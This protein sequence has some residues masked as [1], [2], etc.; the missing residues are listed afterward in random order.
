MKRTALQVLIAGVLAG[1]I[2]FFPITAAFASGPS[3]EVGGVQVIPPLVVQ[4]DG[5][6]SPLCFDLTTQA[7]FSLGFSRGTSALYMMRFSDDRCTTGGVMLAGWS[8]NADATGA[9]KFQASSS[10]GANAFECANVGC[11]LQLGSDSRYFFDS[12]SMLAAQGSFAA[13]SFLNAN[14][15]TAGMTFSSNAMTLTGNVTDGASAVGITLKNATTLANASAKLVSG[16]N[17]ATEAFYIKPNGDYCM[18]TGTCLSSATGSGQGD[19][20]GN[21]STYSATTDANVQIGHCRAS[22]GQTAFTCTNWETAP[23]SGT[24]GTPSVAATGQ[25]EDRIWLKL[26]TSLANTVVGAAN[27]TSQ[28]TLMLGWSTTTTFK[29]W[30]KS[31]TRNTSYRYAIGLVNTPSTVIASDTPTNNGAWFA[32]RTGT[33][34]TKWMCCSSDGV[35]AATCTSSNTDFALSSNYLLQIDITPGT[36]VVYKIN[37]TTVCTRDSGNPIPTTANADSTETFSPMMYARTGGTAEGLDLFVHSFSV[38][39]TE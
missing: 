33:T 8:V 6:K 20:A 22:Y 39:W 18:S 7:G 3:V 10:S 15:T 17:N 4:G 2:A 25:Y 30:I 23:T 9:P 5:S 21:V 26:S 16:V 38:N 27:S 12:G 31:T 13:T 19:N 14:G 34:D 37:G 11:R 29:T 35:S 36:Q 24:V 28:G 32:Y 1:I